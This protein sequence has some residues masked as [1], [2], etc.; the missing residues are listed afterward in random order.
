MI[1]MKCETLVTLAAAAR[2]RPPGRNGRPTHPST[3]FRWTTRGVRGCRLEA[4][5]LGAATYTSVEAL[6][7]FA[8]RL[9]CEPAAAHPH[10]P[11]ASSAGTDD[12]LDRLG[13]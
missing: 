1:D 3:I 12:A 10:A 13:F 9:A 2:L 5:R 7:R 11:T 6:Q 8:D 4:V